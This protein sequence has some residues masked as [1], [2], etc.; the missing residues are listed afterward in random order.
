MEEVRNEAHPYFNDNIRELPKNKKSEF[1]ISKEN[2]H[3][4]YDN[5]VDVF[6]HAYAS[7]VFTQVYN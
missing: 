4:F 7:G 6:P 5:D 1:E 2:K 3:L